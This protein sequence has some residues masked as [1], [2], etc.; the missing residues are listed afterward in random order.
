MIEVLHTAA[1][2][3]GGIDAHEQDFSVASAA[4]HNEGDAVSVLGMSA[5]GMDCENLGSALGTD[6][7]CMP[8]KARQAPP[9]G[10]VFLLGVAQHGEERTTSLGSERERGI[11]GFL[12]AVFHFLVEDNGEEAAQFVIEQA[13]LVT[14]PTGNEDNAGCLVFD[15]ALQQ[16]GLLPGEHTIPDADIP[17]EDDIVF[18]QVLQFVG[19]G[20]YVVGA[21]A[22]PELRMEKEA[23]DINAG[24]TRKGVADEAIFPPWQ[25]LHDED[26]DRFGTACDVESAPVVLLDQF[27]VGKGDGEFEGGAA[28]LLQAPE[29][30]I[31]VGASPW[32]GDI[33]GALHA[34]LVTDADDSADISLKGGLDGERDLNVLTDDTVGRGFDGEEV[35]IG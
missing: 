22:F 9:D 20:G 23:I 35:E 14:L 29:D 28:F 15:E 2:A 5:V 24:I 1:P 7:R 11:S 4:G 21:V 34:C 30:G 25:G 6:D 19:E 26:P 10:G 33:L 32:D 3:P 27:A 17:D 31:V 8:V 13:E 18:L 12:L 16:C